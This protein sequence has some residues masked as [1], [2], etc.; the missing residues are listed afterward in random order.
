MATFLYRCPVDGTFEMHWPV[1]T[2]PGQVTCPECASD[3]RRVYTPPLVS[4][5]SREAMA[6][7]DQTERTRYEPE[8]V[9]RPAR[10]GRPRRGAALNPAW[11]GLPRP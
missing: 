2:A 10:P 1:G 7:I 9:T 6:L 3:A 5:G 4:G 11:Q 8:V